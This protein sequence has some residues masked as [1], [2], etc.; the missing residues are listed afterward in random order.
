MDKIRVGIMGAGGYG[1]CGAIELLQNHPYVEISGLFAKQDIGRPISELY[2]HLNGFCD[3]LVRAPDDPESSCDFQV[4]F[5]ATPDG[6]G[7]NRARNWLEKGA[8]VI[9]YS[10]DFR[11]TTIEN[12][13]G[14]ARRMGRSEAHASPDLLPHSVYGLTELHRQDIS[15]SNLVGN[16]GCFAVSCILGAS[17]AIHSKLVDPDSL[18]F[19]AKTGVSGAGKTPHAAFHYPA[20][21]ESMNAYKIAG[22]QHVY[23][24]EKEL[25]ILAGRPITVTFTPHVVPLCRGIL[26]TIYAQLNPGQTL[27][28]VEEAYRA[29]YKDDVFVRIFGPETPQASVNVRGSNFCNISLNLD[30]RTGKLIVVSLIDNLV[31]GQA[32]SA[33]QNMNVMLGLDET[34][35]LAHPGV[36][37]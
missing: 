23:E 13:K 4:V 33:V 1:G 2:P 35:G 7:Q 20:R 18:I 9:D 22:H 24:I 5:F 25:S 14:Y 30:E 17:P 32:G 27:K 29:F 8:K 12:Y 11:F 3:L 28:T 36:Y 15:R 10:G 19:D 21:Y 31:K 34:I 16:P 6:V 26:T 37:P